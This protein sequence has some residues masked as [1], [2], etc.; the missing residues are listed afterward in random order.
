VRE[1]QRPALSICVATTAGWPAMKPCLRSFLDDG[2]SVG[3][4]ILVADGSGAQPPDNPAV[5]DG[6]TWRSY[7]EQSVFRLVD[8]NLR[9]ARGEIVAMTEDHCTTRPGWVEAILRAHREYPNAAA[10][11]GAIE[12]G[13]TG[14]R[15][16]WASY[17]ITQSQHM[18]PLHNGPAL[19]IAN[20]ANVS[21]KR[22]ALEGMERHPLGFMTIR[23]LRLLAQAGAELVNDDRIV[24]DHHES[25]ST[26]ATS[27]IQ[28]DD[29]RTISGFRR[30]KM[31]KG[32]W[33]RLAAAPVLPLLRSARV[34]RTTVA[35]RR[36]S[37]LATSL[38]WIA[39]LE[40]CH[41]AGEFVGYLLGP[42]RSPY[43]LR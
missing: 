16:E 3:A 10:I 2:R 18:A 20:E 5:T 27:T 25:L 33:A 26:R 31:G 38:L 30:R 13:T 19:R 8:F 17:L 42:G 24:V 41:G 9:A 35:K 39:W 21:F 12:N 23:H 36:R 11:G 28:F 34:A 40:Y 22:A 15:L 7:A 29:G 32:D 6:V 1:D 37:T 14:S 4:E 43:G